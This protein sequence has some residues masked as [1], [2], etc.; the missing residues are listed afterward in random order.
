M[1]Q[2]KTLFV[3][4][5][6][7]KNR[8]KEP[9]RLEKN[10]CRF[11]VVVKCWEVKSRESISLFNVNDVLRMIYHLLYSTTKSQIHCIKVRS[12]LWK[13]GI[14]LTQRCSAVWLLFRFYLV[15]YWVK[16][17]LASYRI[18]VAAIVL[19]IVGSRVTFVPVR[20]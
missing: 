14:R 11:Y 6:K 15:L 20:F 13:E 2:L 3:H 10:S 7:Q 9:Y 4:V 19:I 17:F 1:R 8:K 5:V 16:I 12:T 18:V